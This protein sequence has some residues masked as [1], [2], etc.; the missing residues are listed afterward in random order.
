MDDDDGARRRVCVER[1]LC[2]LFNRFVV[3]RNFVLCGGHV[4]HKKNKKKECIRS[5]GFLER[6]TRF[7]LGALLGN[8]GQVRVP[9][10]KIVISLRC[11]ATVKVGSASSTIQPALSDVMRWSGPNGYLVPRTRSHSPVLA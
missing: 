2:L 1:L 8:M 6:V 7:V 10:L 3:C 11:Q 4:A 5:T 9:L